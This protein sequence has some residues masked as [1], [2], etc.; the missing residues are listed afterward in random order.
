MKFTHTRKLRPSAQTGFNLVELSVA[1]AIVAVLLVGALMGTRQIMMSNMVNTQTRDAASV[2][3]KVKRLYVNQTSTSGAST[4]SLGPQ[5]IWPPERATVNSATDTKVVGAITGS[6]EYIFANTADIGTMTANTGFIY[7]LNKVQKEACAE[8]VTALDALAFAIY[9][10][11][12]AAPTT[13]ATPS[14]T[15][16]KAGD[17]TLSMANLGTGCAAATADGVSIAVAFKMR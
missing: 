6:N 15:V 3:N 2:I 11:A 10:G 14:T 7:T 8:L 12:P 5:G 17:G 4:A 16:V 13:G 1:L 9:V